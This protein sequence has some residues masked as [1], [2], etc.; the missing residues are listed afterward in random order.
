LALRR[1]VH[2]EGSSVR[3]HWLRKTAEA[4]VD[5][6]EAFT[7][8]RGEPDWRGQTWEY[9]QA[10][11]EIFGLAGVE[12]EDHETVS[13]AVRYHAGNVLR[14]RLD[15]EELTS[16]GLRTVSPRERS[17]ERQARVSEVLASV[18][19][20][21]HFDSI[22]LLGTSL[23]MLLQVEPDDIRGASLREQNEVRKL[24]DKNVRA[25][26]RLNDKIHA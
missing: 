26:S 21:E 16:L 1:Y 23:A 14:E 20:M 15:D 17:S 5:L 11:N 25:L 4:I 13:A 18:R 7:T 19:G 12:P 6:R 22:R 10:V 24:I 2:E 3:T 9:R 8:E